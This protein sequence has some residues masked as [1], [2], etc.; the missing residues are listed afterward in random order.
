MYDGLIRKRDYFTYFHRVGGRT[1]KPWKE[2]RMIDIKAVF[3]IKI[4]R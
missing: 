1:M 2:K 3:L 4:K